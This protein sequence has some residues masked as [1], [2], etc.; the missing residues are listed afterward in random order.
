MGFDAVF[1]YLHV[2]IDIRIELAFVVQ[3]LA[4]S[5]AAIRDQG[6]QFVDKHLRKRH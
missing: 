4:L 2:A 3:S 5:C 6:S 1:G